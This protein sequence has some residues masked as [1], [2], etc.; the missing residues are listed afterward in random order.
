MNQATDKVP[1]VPRKGRP[2]K[3]AT[4]LSPALG[5]SRITK[6]AFDAYGPAADVTGN[7]T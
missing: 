1:T 2:S 3:G 4:P 5:N 6:Q 7:D